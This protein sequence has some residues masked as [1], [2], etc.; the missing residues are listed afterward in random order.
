MDLYVKLIFG[1]GRPL[2]LIITHFFFFFAL[3]LLPRG[4]FVCA[5][6]CSYQIPNVNDLVFD[7]PL[8]RNSDDD[9]LEEETFESFSANRKTRSTSDV[10]KPLRIHL[11]YDHLS[12]SRLSE[13]IQ[14]F[15]N[16]SLLP[17]AAGYW[18]QALAVRPAIAPIRLA[19]KCIQDHYF[20]R[21]R[22]K[23]NACSEGCRAETTC[24][25]VI[26]PDEHLYQCHYCLRRHPSSCISSGIGDGP[27]VA[28]ADFILYVSAVASERCKSVE[29]V[30]YAAH[31]QQEA[32]FDRPIAGHVN[33]CPNS[34]STEAHDQEVLISTVKHEILHA[35]GFS[36]GLYAFFRDDNGEPRT[37][38]N[39]YGKPLSLNVERHFYNW[40]ENT[41]RTIERKDW[42][43][44]DGMVSHSV[45]VM[46][47]PQVQKE[48]RAHFDCDQLEGAELE[49]QGGDGTALTHWEKRLFENEAMTGTHTQNPVYTR[50]TLALLEDSGWYKANYSIAEELQW[51]KGLGCDFA[52]KSCG[53]WI[54]KRR[55]ANLTPA[56]FCDEIKHDGKKSLATTK[57]TVERDSLALCNL[58]P[59]HHSLPVEYRNF[60]YLLGVRAEGLQYYGGSVELADYC[61]Y[62][63]E[64]EWKAMNSTSRRDSRCELDG[65]FA[66]DESNSILEVYGS[67]SKC[68]D[69]AAAWT[70]RK[71]R[72]IRTFVQY[73]A[74][75]YQYF[76]MDGRLYVQVHNSSDIYPCYHPGQYIYVKRIV[77]GWLREGVIICPA[78]EEMCTSD[79][80]T[81]YDEPFGCRPPE[82]PPV[83]YIGD[84]PLEEPC[85]ASLTTSLTTLSL[86]LVLYT[87]TSIDVESNVI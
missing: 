85:R 73:L 52:M 36:A 1:Q 63:Q 2:T 38:R 62:S 67:H 34:L 10:F 82:D 64:F 32:E 84:P 69:L 25:E 29:T 11:H 78:C 30:A 76:C 37:K 86:L 55:K 35:L 68:F 16:S 27:G 14:F 12:V 43:T 70:E 6:P 4:I 22:A 9:S 83:E 54:Q 58:V 48:V 8:E 5:F 21:P 19:R 28:D 42:W 59:H 45:H 57:C 39:R 71:C 26:V 15:V 66:P 49:N 33:L 18:E 60:D 40:D 41:I 7:V 81:S 79:S 65:N 46:V 74:G 50:L 31:C 72:R 17:E 20:V 51:G 13:E 47:T 75:C 77:N 56:P 23:V 44:A 3:V 80:F 24:G 87:F 53:E 61:P